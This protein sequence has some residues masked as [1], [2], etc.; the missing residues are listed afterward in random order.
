MKHVHHHIKEIFKLLFVN[1]VLIIVKLVFQVL[2]NYAY[3]DISFKMVNVFHH[4]MM[5]IINLWMIE[6]VNNVMQF[7][8]HVPVQILMNV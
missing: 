3:L 7:V 2:V 4:V 6:S 5:V 1:F 8:K